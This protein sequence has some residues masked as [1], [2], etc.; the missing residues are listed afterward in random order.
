MKGRI[1][2]YL[3]IQRVKRVRFSSL[4]ERQLILFKISI[5]RVFKHKKQTIKWNSYFKS[6][7]SVSG[8]FSLKR[9]AVSSS[10]MVGT[11]HL[12]TVVSCGDVISEHTETT[13]EWSCCLPLWCHLKNCVLSKVCVWSVR[14][15]VLPLLL[16]EEMGCGRRTG[17]CECSFSLQDYCQ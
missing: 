10:G 1:S 11:P 9:Q 5:S 15:N 3:F 4:I 12:L 17:L 14:G 7:R 8:N 16:E 2:S 6:C 13:Q